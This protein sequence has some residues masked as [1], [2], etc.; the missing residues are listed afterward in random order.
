MRYSTKHGPSK[1]RNALANP[2]A[3]AIAVRQIHQHLRN[4]QTLAYVLD[5][6]EDAADQLGH[7]AWIIGLGTE[8]AFAVQHPRTRM[9]HGA[10]RTVH[11]MALAGYRWQA[12]QAP[13]VDAAL[14]ESAT[15]ITT[16]ADIAWTMLA[17]AE[18]LAHRISTRTTHRD[19]VAGA[20]IYATPPAEIAPLAPHAHGGEGARQKAGDEDDQQAPAGPEGWKAGARLTASAGEVMDDG[21][22]L[23][24]CPDG[25]STSTEGAC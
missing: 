11:A 17:G 10:L 19:D 25:A 1:R 6:G 4:I 23:Q 24:A 18:L 14:G 5:D 20:E 12:A 22:A 3:K 8:V 15:L 2:V 16:H 9:L 21:Q 13:V 7:M